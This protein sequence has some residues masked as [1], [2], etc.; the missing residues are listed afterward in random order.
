MMC[1]RKWSLTWRLNIKRGRFSLKLIKVQY[2]TANDS[3]Q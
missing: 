1:I 3:K 2:V